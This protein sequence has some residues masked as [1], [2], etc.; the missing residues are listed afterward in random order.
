LKKFDIVIIGAGPGGSFA[1]MIA[2]EEGYSTCLIEKEKL[3][4]NGRY[5]ACGGAIPWELIEE[6]NYPEDKISRIFD[7]LELHHV[8]GESFTKKTKGALVWR[9]IFD[10]YLSDLAKNSGVLFRDNNRLI[11]IE[12]TA[13]SYQIITQKEKFSADYIIAADG[14]NST[15]IK[16][17]N[18]PYFKKEDLALTITQERRSSKSYI[19]KTLGSNSV[20]LFFGIK[21]LIPVGYAYLF[22]KLEKIT[23]G[24]GSQ[25]NLI[26]NSR[27]EFDKFIQLPY[28]KK[29][30]LNSRLEKYTAHLIP[31][32]ERP[33]LFENN[34][35]AVG[36]AGGFVDPIN[37]AGIP[38]AMMSGQYAIDSIKKCENR[39]K[40]GELGA[41]YE[42]L[43][44]RKFL[45]ILR[46]KRQIRD[47]IFSNDDTLKE[48]LS[49]W[50]KH[51]SM[52][53]VMKKLI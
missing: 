15:T 39:G 16:L 36:D 22:P 14:V 23:V 17:L 38:Y 26:K 13:G 2:A 21:D 48:F 50:E 24:W 4:K 44:E 3:G 10:K 42:K 30:L 51:D 47:K 28:V 31:M 20:H 32:G 40:L 6:I 5:K 34:V 7:S 46:L 52:E 29:A 9:N 41:Y 25:I 11:C 43:L 18:W 8:D 33:I 19:D 1:A 53:I 37:G 49:L 12:K 35:F 45:K 27:I